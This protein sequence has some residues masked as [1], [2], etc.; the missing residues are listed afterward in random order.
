MT[1]PSSSNMVAFENSETLCQ[2]LKANHATQSELLVKIYKKGSGVPCVTWNDL[3][4]ECLCWGWIDGVK[5][6]LDS[7]AY[8]QRIT[9]RKPHSNWSKRNT[10]HVERL[11]KEGRMQEP[12]MLHV[13][14]AKADGRWDSAYTVSDIQVPKDFIEALKDKPEAKAFYET[15]TKSS[16]YVI[17]LGLTSAKKPETRLKRFSK[18]L[19]MLVNKVKPV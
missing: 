1:K 8:I 7:D 3:V 13:R 15:L 17:A 5:K 19:D 2:W 9:P 4:V 18:Y 6:S 11:I 16:R 10:E 14:A 12:G